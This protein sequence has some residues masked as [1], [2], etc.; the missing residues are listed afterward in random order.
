MDCN[1]WTYDASQPMEFDIKKQINNV[2]DLCDDIKLIV[3]DIRL[4]RRD[5]NTIREK[6][7]DVK[8]EGYVHTEKI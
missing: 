2:L 4:L 5:I 6:L 1:I 3:N 8:S 7:K